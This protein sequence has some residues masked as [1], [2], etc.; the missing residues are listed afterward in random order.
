MEEWE[1]RQKYGLLTDNQHPMHKRSVLSTH[2]S[3]W[4]SPIARREHSGDAVFQELS[5][6]AIINLAHLCLLVMTLRLESH[7]GLNHAAR[8][9]RRFQKTDCGQRCSRP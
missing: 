3:C 9:C 6:T 8:L 5:T 2:R 4:P 7:D 1:V